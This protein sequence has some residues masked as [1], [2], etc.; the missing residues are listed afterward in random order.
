MWDSFNGLSQQICCWVDGIDPAKNSDSMVVSWDPGFIARW[1]SPMEPEMGRSNK[2]RGER[3]SKWPFQLPPP[4]G[5]I[6]SMIFVELPYL[7]YVWQSP[8]LRGLLSWKISN[9]THFF[10][11]IT[12]T[13]HV[14]YCS[15]ESCICI[16][17]DGSIHQSCGLERDGISHNIFTFHGFPPIKCEVFHIEFQGEARQSSF[18]NISVYKRKKQQTTELFDLSYDNF[19]PSDFC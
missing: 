6:G 7:N 16:D 10:T 19:W 9:T 8:E 3:I 5:C 15:P 1:I 18:L 2:Q 11:R 4:Q 12:R 13:G 17:Q 14:L